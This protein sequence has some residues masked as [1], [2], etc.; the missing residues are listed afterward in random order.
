[1]KDP[2]RYMFP[3][4]LGL[5]SVVSA[6][7]IALML[8]GGIRRPDG[9][10]RKP[11]EIVFC[12]WGGPEERQIFGFLVD[13]FMKENPD[14]KVRIIHVPQNYIQKLQ[15]MVAGG[16]APDVFFL[17]DADFPAFVV[18]QTMR[19]LT[20]FIRRSKVI[21]EKDFWPTALLRYKYD[22]VR[23]RLGEGDLYA[24]PKDIGPFAMFYN[25]DLFRRAG[26]PYPSAV[27]PL[28]WDPA[29]AMWKKLTVPD[30]DHP[31]VID[32]FGVA[33]FTWE[34]AVWSNGGEIISKDGRT[35]VM[36]D[37][38]RSAEA[39]Q[40][41]ADLSL[42][43]HCAPNTREAR[44]FDPGPMF[45]T[46]K[47]ACIIAGRWMVPHYRKLGFDWD[48][49]PIPKS[50]RGKDWTGWSGSIGL[51][52]S[53]NCRDQERAWRLIEFLAG[54]H[55]QSV[56]ATTGFQIPNQRYL[57]PTDVFLQRS[58]RPQHAEVFIAGARNQRPGILTLAPTNEWADEF[59]QR[60][61]PIWE[62]KLTAA[63]GLKRIKPYA[64]KG[65]DNAWQQD[66]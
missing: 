52:M 49:A 35:F 7:L 25:K 55:G 15:I 27:K 23:R 9:W 24:L 37:D 47:L 5:L 53:R 46:G 3:L 65:L 29:V 1:M 17:P 26:V 31:G 20:P 64:Q 16:T 59:F 19:P 43:Y 21:H 56:Q 51:A 22:N 48:V 6:A 2:N 54:P 8:F 60:I 14:I 39:L 61:T 13:E 34:S 58:Q 63:E 44:S 45:D 50:P 57:A 18:K 62:G 32:Q 38:P 4:Y 66:Q 36:A 12:I 10:E 40:W 33:N 11:N 41:V 30:K 42:R 28:D